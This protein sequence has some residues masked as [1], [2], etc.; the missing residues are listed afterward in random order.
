MNHFKQLLLFLTLTGVAPANLHAQ[1]TSAFDG[2]YLGVSIEGTHTSSYP[3]AKCIPAR[4]APA[5]LTVTNGLI[6]GAWEGSVSPGGAF[7]ARSSNG[8][9]IVGQIGGDGAMRAVSGGTA[10]TFNFVWRKASSG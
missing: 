7:A 5:R 1:S 9:Q 3:G 6:H 8:S 4:N 10:C 2:T